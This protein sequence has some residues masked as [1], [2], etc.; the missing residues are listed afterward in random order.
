MFVRI[1]FLFKIG[2][3]DSSVFLFVLSFSD[4]ANPASILL[5]FF[6]QAHFLGPTS[7]APNCPFNFILHLAFEHGHIFMM[8]CFCHSPFHLG[9]LSP[10]NSPFV[11][12]K[13]ARVCIDSLGDA[14][15]IVNTFVRHKHEQMAD[16]TVLGNRGLSSQTSRV[17]SPQI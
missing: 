8:F 5:G 17:K 16:S 11:L 4:T 15:G 1:S 9:V 12:V 7:A 2:N 10:R 3:Q 14:W 6:S 13:G